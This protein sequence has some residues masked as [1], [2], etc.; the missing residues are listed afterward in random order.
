M[1]EFSCIASGFLKC[2]GSCAYCSATSVQ[3]VDFEKK[4]IK[5]EDW[6]KVEWDF[7]A[8]KK[9][10]DTNPIIQ[11]HLKNGKKLTL[12]WWA[13]E[14]LDWTKECDMY[15]DWVDKNYPNLNY[16]LFI[17][18]NAIPL[19]RKKVVEWIYEQKEKHDLHIQISH[20]GVGQFIRT[21]T[22][23]PFY[24]EKTKDV[25]VK[26]AKDGIFTMI[27]ATLNNYNCSPLANFQYF[28]KWRYENHLEHLPLYIKLNHNNDSDYTLK[29]RL[30]D[31]N[32]SR[33]IHELE[34]LWM[35][36]YVAPEND[37]YWQPYRSYFL[38]QMSRSEQFKSLGGCGQ[39]ASGQ[40]DWTWCMNTKGEYV[41]C[42]LCNDPK[43]VINPKCEQSEACK[44]CEYRSFDDCSPCPDM[45]MSEDCGPGH[46]SYKQEFIRA[47]LRMRT[48]MSIVDA[49]RRR[50]AELEGTN[51]SCNCNKKGGC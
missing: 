29:Y 38:N 41:W 7:D 16:D 26:L 48:F 34:N 47:T 33:Y 8:M 25:I 1:S 28:Q 50:I 40:K 19:A 5:K 6:G 51:K 32:L 23:D 36:A 43:D 12:N 27:N 30:R 24:D 44:H 46:Y 14:P 42:Q 35:Q 17:S 37:I 39:F 18:T 10:F 3:D 9:I 20:D 45:K 21:K 2:S 31:Y 13:A 49:Q 4:G 15:T 22:F 11:E